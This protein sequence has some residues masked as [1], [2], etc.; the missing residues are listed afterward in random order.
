MSFLFDNYLK[1]LEFYLIRD[2]ITGAGCQ[3]KVNR[4]IQT[5]DFLCMFGINPRFSVI[6]NCSGKAVFMSLKFQPQWKRKI[7]R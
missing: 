3:T 1:V 7:F 2:L 5:G 6:T 4:S